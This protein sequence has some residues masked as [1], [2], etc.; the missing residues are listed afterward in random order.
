MLLCSYN[1][2]SSDGH[3]AAPHQKDPEVGKDRLF[4]GSLSIDGR[5]CRPLADQIFTHWLS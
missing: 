1:D 3:D 2:L 5:R 4:E